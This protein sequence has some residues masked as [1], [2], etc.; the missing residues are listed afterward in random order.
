[1]EHR[2]VYILRPV[3]I[4]R[5]GQIV[6]LELG[7]DGRSSTGV[8][9]LVAD[10]GWTPWRRWPTD[11]KS[12]FGRRVISS[13]GPMGCNLM[14]RPLVW[15]SEEIRRNPEER[16]AA[17]GLY[18]PGVL[19]SSA[20]PDENADDRSVRPSA[21][22]VTLGDGDR[23]LFALRIAFRVGGFGDCVSRLITNRAA[24]WQELLF[25]YSMPARGGL[26]ELRGQALRNYPSYVLYG[27]APGGRL[28]ARKWLPDASAPGGANRA[29][30]IIALGPKQDGDGV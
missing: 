21:L 15:A 18:Q 3:V 22:R 17:T 8:P 25:E 11:P 4:V 1:M 13:E 23:A 2:G 5:R 29:C 7:P 27:R 14:E 12:E 20:R 26:D 9:L 30:E 10:A 6:G 16:L 19:K 24:P 28:G